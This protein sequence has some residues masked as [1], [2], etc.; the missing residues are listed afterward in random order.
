MKKVTLHRITNG[1]SAEPDGDSDGN[2]TA[3]LSF[4]NEKIQNTDYSV[5]K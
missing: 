4:F 1:K 3:K 2:Q 5:A